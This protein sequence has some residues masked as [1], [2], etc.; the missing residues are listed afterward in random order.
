[1]QTR[2][3]AREVPSL[4]VHELGYNLPTVIGWRANLPST[5][6]DAFARI[7]IFEQEL[8]FP[9]LEANLNL[10]H[11]I[12]KYPLDGLK[13]KP[14]PKRTSEALTLYPFPRIWYILISRLSPF[15]DFMLAALMDGHLLDK[16]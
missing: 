6:D 1:M 7:S 5:I 10:D 9:T 14:D 11:F 2:K 4:V 12:A 15:R 8:Y 16:I 13:S 3:A